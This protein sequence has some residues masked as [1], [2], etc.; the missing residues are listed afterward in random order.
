ME[1]WTK[2]RGRHPELPLLLALDGAQVEIKSWLRVLPNKRYVGRG[3]WC[4]K[5]VL[6][7]LF[8][9]QS[10]KRDA[11]RERHGV[12]L[13]ADRGVPTP[14][15]LHTYICSRQ[16]CLLTKFLP[17]A[18][19]LAEQWRHSNPVLPL[20]EAHLAR[21]QRALELLASLHQ[22]GIDH[23]D[24]HLGNI[25]VDDQ[26]LL[27]LD[28]DSVR[29]TRDGSLSPDRAL[30]GLAAFL[31]CFGVDLTDYLP[32]L[33]RA[34]G[35]YP[36]GVN[37]LQ[38]AI[39][40]KQMQRMKAH[41]KKRQRESTVIA[42]G[43]DK[44]SKV[45]LDRHLAEQYELHR[46]M[47][48]ADQFFTDDARY[49]KKGNTATVISIDWGGRQWILK[50]YNIKSVGHWL[51]RFW[52]PSR[53]WHS[54]L[55]SHLLAFL[56]VPAARAAAV[57]ENRRWGLRG[58]AWL[59]QVPVSGDNIVNRWQRYA[60]EDVLPPTQELESVICLLRQLRHYRLGHGDLKGSNILWNGEGWYLIDLDS[61]RVYKRAN[62]YKQAW[63]RDRSRFLRNWPADSR[64]Y[65]Y[66]DDKLAL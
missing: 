5:D 12:Q 1:N 26:R 37:A 57:R 6:I 50:R 28:G 2:L 31:C 24:L 41:L 19:S 17:D 14:E 29:A 34:Y 62:R 47:Q 33:E 13:M 40:Q 58:K 45:L 27:V 35:Q 56:G 16:S 36:G 10:A 7:K 48:E 21:V 32:Q 44:D 38:Q 15:L 30:K 65:R 43:D 4:G 55:A 49:L 60:V 53:A 59:L 61:L 22:K 25:L 51:Q 46:L 9:G 52:R 3:V 20:Q 42:S 54:W 66:L 8:V 11:R 23:G 18:Q 39:S 63:Q 64:I